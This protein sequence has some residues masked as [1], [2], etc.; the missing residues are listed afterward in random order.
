MKKS[1]LI[2]CLLLASLG[3][4]AQ[5]EKG[6]WM[7]NTSMTSMD[8]SYSDSDKGH[9]GF[10][11]EGGTFLEDNIALLL[12]LGADWSDPK[13]TYTLGA[14]GRYYFEKTGVYLGAGLNMKRW[15]YGGT[16]AS[17]YALGLQ[18]GYAYF[19]SRTVTIEPAVYYDLSLK[20][21]NNSKIGFKLGFGFYF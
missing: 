2:I 1:V 17:D 5:F 15:Y 21:G 20:N 4:Q 19:L 6:K 3:A 13:D 12:T 9:L 14:N 8:F 7:V 10:L 16:H 18:G 11:A